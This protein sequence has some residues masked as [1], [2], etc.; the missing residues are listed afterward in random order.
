MFSDLWYKNNYFIIVTS[1]KNNELKDFIMLNVGVC[2]TFSK[3]TF[4]KIFQ[5]FSW[6]A[7]FFASA[8]S[9]RNSTRLRFAWAWTQVMIFRGFFNNQSYMLGKMFSKN[10]IASC[11]RA[12]F[13]LK[14]NKI[15]KIILPLLH[16]FSE[17]KH[18]KLSAIIVKFLFLSCN[19]FISQ[20]LN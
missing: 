16:W 18:W 10:K 8:H 7:H 14:L 17:N 4:W 13:R 20:S 2:L 9:I 3:I 11:K 1:R 12:F 6:E 5:S 19:R 15:R